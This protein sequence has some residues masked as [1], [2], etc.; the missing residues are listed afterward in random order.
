MKI[1][2]AIISVTIFWFLFSSI[3]IAASMPYSPVIKNEKLKLFVTSYVLQSW[4]FFSRNPRESNLNIYSL[5]D[6][7]E[8]ILA[9]NHLPSNI[10]G[11]DRKARAQG[12]EAAVLYNQVKEE[13]IETCE[14]NASECLEEMSISQKIFNE[15][16][17]PTL[18]GEIGLALKEPIP[19]SWGK[20]ENTV[21]KSELSKVEV[22]CKNG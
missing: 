14:F 7:N 1:K 15:T 16:Q 20:F 12:V 9:P 10:L 2:V 3:S 5:N 19:W 17:E 13:N 4:G 18:C 11:L 21:M 8:S 22:I 6:D